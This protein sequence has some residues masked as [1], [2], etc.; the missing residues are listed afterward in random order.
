[1]DDWSCRDE[2]RS[3]G[4]LSTYCGYYLKSYAGQGMECCPL[5]HHE[6]GMFHAQ[7]GSLGMTVNSEAMRGGGR[8][9]FDG[10]LKVECEERLGANWTGKGGGRIGWAGTR[11]GP[12]AEERV[13]YLTVRRRKRDGHSCY[14][15]ENKS[16]KGKRWNPWKLIGK[17]TV[18][19]GER[20]Q[21]CSRRRSIS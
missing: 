3:W 18:R 10:L 12:V 11:C 17:R 5:D 4:S 1:M 2:G 19:E 6:R 9:G 14:G 20:I 21:T 16:A 15:R 8:T 13:R 7:D